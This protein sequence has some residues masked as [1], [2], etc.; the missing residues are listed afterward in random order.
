[1]HEPSTNVVPL[2]A[3]SRENIVHG[4]RAIIEVTLSQRLSANENRG[5][6][7]VA[8]GYLDNRFE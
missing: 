3:A 7:R 6:A 1:V 8:A 4:A 2:Q 5:N